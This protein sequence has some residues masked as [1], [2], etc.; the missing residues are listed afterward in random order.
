MKGKARSRNRNARA[1]YAAIIFVLFLLG[2]TTV[3]SLSTCT[4]IIAIQASPPEG[5]TTNIITGAVFDSVTGRGIPGVRIQVHRA[6]SL[7][8]SVVADSHGA[9]QIRI[10]GEFRCRIYALPLTKSELG[11]SA[12]YGSAV[13][14]VVLEGRTVVNLTFRLLP[15]AS[16]MLL[17]DID[18]VDLN[19]LP[20]SVNFTV[21]DALSEKQ[22]ETEGF[23]SKYGNQSSFLR[24]NQ[25]IVMI[26]V[27]FNVNVRVDCGRTVL[28][29]FGWLN[30]TRSFT[31]DNIP[32]ARKGD[33]IE[34]K[35]AKYTSQYNLRVAESLSAR[36]KERMRGVET[37]G[38]YV[39]AEKNDLSSIDKLILTGKEKIDV[40]RYEESYARLSEAH[41]RGL[42]LADR[43]DILLSEAYWSAIFF[44][45][46]LAFSGI[47]LATF[48]FER[49]S[50]KLLGFACS[51]LFLL[52]WFNA[53]FPGCR[54]VPEETYLKAGLLTGAIAILALAALPNLVGRAHGQIIPRTV[55][56]S[57]AKRNLRRRKLRT[58]LVLTTIVTLMLGFVA[59][60]SFSI[61]YGFQS[62][63]RRISLRSVG[64]LIREANPHGGE[65]TPFASLDPTNLP[66]LSRR[67]G[68]TAAA[69]KMESPPQLRI[70][71]DSTPPSKLMKL[72][73]GTLRPP[74]GKEP[75]L[76]LG[77][78]GF[79]P[80]AERQ[81]THL[82][83][84]IVEGRFLIE[85]EG[86]GVVITRRAAQTNGFKIGDSLILS[87]GG[88]QIL[89]VLTG[90]LDDEGLREQRDLDGESILPQ[91][92][93]RR[94]GSGE[95]I[96]DELVRC[97]PAD[98]IIATFSLAQALPGMMMSRVCLAISDDV[99]GSDLGRE[100]VYARDYWVWVAG[101]EE[102]QWM[103]LGTYVETKGSLLV[104]PLALVLLNMGATMFTVVHE[105][106]REILTLSSLGVSPA[107]I[108]QLF[109]AEALVVA[110]MGAGIGYLVG[111]SFYRIMP[112]LSLGLE[113]REKVE[114]TWS[115]V[116]TLLAIAVTLAGTFLPS[117]QASLISTPLGLSR[118]K[119][120][121]KEEPEEDLGAEPHLKEQWTIPVP[122]R[123]RT[124]EADRFM[125]FVQ[126]KFSQLD[127]PDQDHIEKMMRKD[128]K[129]EGKVVRRL[130]FRHVFRDRSSFGFFTSR[131]VLNVGEGAEGYLEVE[132]LVGG[133]RDRE[134]LVYFTADLIRKLALEWSTKKDK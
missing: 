87:T 24:M 60:T 126:E 104:I 97:D 130:Q 37:M 89:T 83:R 59:L 99:H 21:L 86:D 75:M 42:R 133:G 40:S 129:I 73:L 23:L 68:V 25:N 12:E 62:G 47:A 132:L 102:V 94:I 101:M 77:L 127:D 31:I 134:A 119:L 88:K 105:R 66:W 93:Y 20:T 98:I 3:A 111:L 45:L 107:S 22:F 122:I 54:L 124:S 14:D 108:A 4:S 51:Y 70:V 76:I 30:V 81:I 128:E 8:G 50:L 15:V 46:F 79:S 69:P 125:I 35:V 65:F 1:K 5:Q 11:V 34:I 74:N 112:I 29:R 110:L 27:G 82:D 33:T 131:C 116:A 2:L 55:L 53:V 56:F 118:W 95:L 28:G 36:L 92:R 38:F 96:H 18:L 117:K 91:I 39:V 61:E 7:I 48:L 84:L 90:L 9:F 6:T 85:G 13:K 115:V 41:L 17:G 123:I 10:P 109:M 78:L 121:G 100:L 58:T 57:M 44:I 26:P 72:E 106:Q 49:V 67:E 80:S 16:M 114:V 52:S 63:T 120:T 103:R 43:I 32:E 113:V 19:A 64:V 71:E